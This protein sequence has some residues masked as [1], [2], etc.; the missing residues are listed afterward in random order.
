MQQTSEWA[1]G[2]TS[3]LM[4]LHWYD[5]LGDWNEETLAALRHKLTGELEGYPGLP[6]SRPW[7]FSTAWAIL[8]I[9]RLWISLTYGWTTSKL[10][11]EGV[12]VMICWND[13]GGHWQVIIGYDTMGTSGGRRRVYCGGSLRY[14]RPQPR[15]LRH[16][17]G[18]TVYVQL[19]PCTAN[20]P[21]KKAA[22][23]CCISPQTRTISPA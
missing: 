9:R 19:F 10:A 14:H 13:W 2:V 16:Y 20:S 21:K 1:C 12:P 17:S 7:I 11:Q 3:A 6:Y 8:H 18:G 15:R 22:A 23:I 5:A 4:V